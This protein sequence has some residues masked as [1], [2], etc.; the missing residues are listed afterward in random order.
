[1]T[2]QME[3]SRGLCPELTQGHRRSKIQGQK[4]CHPKYGETK[5]DH[6]F[7]PHAVLQGIKIKDGRIA[8]NSNYIKSRNYQSNTDAGKIVKPE[9]GTYG[10]PDWVAHNED[11]TSIEDQA[12]VKIK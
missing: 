5:F 7:D 6:Y 11:G 1:M 2:Y 9:V 8:Y 12:R 10:E 3:I 4:S